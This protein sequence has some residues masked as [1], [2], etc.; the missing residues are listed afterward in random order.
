ELARVL[1]RGGRCVATVPAMRV[2]WSASDDFYQ[3]RRRYSRPELVA[4]F[5]AAGFELERASFWGFP[6]VLLYDVVLLLPV[7]RRRARSGAVPALARAGRLPILVGLVR[8]LFAIDRLFGWI[9]FGP[10]LLLVAR[11]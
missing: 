11:K 6:M 7:N 2:L 8:A 3:H 5:R 10:G 1:R 9:P 4:L